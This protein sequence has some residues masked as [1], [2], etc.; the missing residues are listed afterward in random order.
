VTGGGTPFRARLYHAASAEHAALAE[1]DLDQ[2]LREAMESNRR[3][4]ARFN[5]PGEF[6]AFYTSLDAATAIA[7]ASMPEAVLVFEA[8]LERIVDL[9]ADPA[10]A[11]WRLEPEALRG[12]DHAPCQAAAQLIRATGNEGVRTPSAKVEGENVALWWDRRLPGSWLR[13]A[14]AEPVGSLAKRRDG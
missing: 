11:H 12:D 1:R 4:G 6:G 2:F 7:E 3:E 14:V 13:L 5:P 8:S 10:C 9:S